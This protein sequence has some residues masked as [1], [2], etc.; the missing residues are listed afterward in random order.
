MLLL[1]LLPALAWGGMA[2]W[3]GAR[4]WAA[5]DLATLSRLGTAQTTLAYV[6]D[7]E[8]WT[9]F[10]L[11]GLQ[12]SVRLV[13]HADVSS[14]W[15]GDS[16][17]EFRYA[18]LVQIT[19][20]LGSVL[21][22][23]VLHQRTGIAAV[24]DTASGE[25]FTSSAYAT[26][27]EVPTA[28]SAIVL[29]LEDLP[30]VAAALRVRLV[31]AAPEVSRVAIRVYQRT[32]LN[33]HRVSVQWDRL[34]AEQRTRLAEGNVYPA[35]LLTETERT[36]LLRRQWKPIGP[37]GVAGRDYRSRSLFLLQ[38]LAG[39]PVDPPALPPGLFLDWRHNGTLQL[40]EAGAKLTLRLE[41]VA[42]LGAAPT[43]TLRFSWYGTSLAQRETREL[44]WSGGRSEMQ[45][46]FGGGLLDLASD[47]P[48]A[49]RAFLP[50][51]T[52]LTAE[53][54]QIRAFVAGP[55]AP[56]TFPILQLDTRATTP[57]RVD[58]RCLCFD[59]LPARGSQAGTPGALPAAA[60][61][62]GA[63][64]TPSLF[65]EMLSADDRV[66]RRGEITVPVEPSPYDRLLGQDSLA[67]SEPAK[68]H[69]DLPSEV[70]ALRFLSSVPV[71]LNGYNRPPD[72]PWRIMTPEDRYAPAEALGTRPAWFGMR[73]ADWNTLLAA[74]RSVL[75]ATH[76][77]PPEDDPELLAGHYDW[78]QFLPDGDWLARD[79]LAPREATPLRR[80][81][82]G[83]V[84][85]PLHTSAEVEL[86]LVPS[87]P[88][89]PVTPT[90]LFLR[91]AP[92][93][94]LLR[95]EVDGRTHFS[96]QVAAVRGTLPMPPLRA[97][98][99]RIRA[100]APAGTALYLNQVTPLPNALISRRAL[101][102]VPGETTFDYEKRTSAD[103]ERPE[104]VVAHLYTQPAP[105]STAR[106]EL[107]ITIEG[108]PPRSLGPHADFTL[109]E[110]VYDIRRGP[111]PPDVR[112]LSAAG[113]LGPERA[114]FVPFGPDL[115]PGR[116]R[117]RVRLSDGPEAL[118]SLTRTTPGVAERRDI[119]REQIQEGR[120]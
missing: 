59:A 22:E 99:R 103:A 45:V 31:S 81:A 119:R 79:V 26:A 65:Y 80:L 18:Y 28:A 85:S 33:E 77:R 8:V 87:T 98:T 40:P 117:I 9:R 46:E 64:A 53:A 15:R 83:T 49:I 62:A 106:Q 13:S 50:D 102:L 36:N 114:L 109:R 4:G 58:L 86:E 30:R 19:D 17:A 116:Y 67:L 32:P 35:T 41:P 72:L 37:S 96:A 78:E 54:P 66:L 89:G 115:P 52:E 92:G 70:V 97:G 71:L 34:T 95:L 68:L 94:G 1:M 39:E 113:L 108:G 56:V 24:R 44:P 118:L 51:G 101:R 47:Q 42:H 90:L 112:V 3:T 100:F 75:L 60:L 57:V 110:R 107:A 2:L 93:P 55:E 74:N 105:G 5:N 43:G 11:A 73:P 16:E 76:P 82:L 10:P 48:V 23:T 111:E 61:L 25:I 88:G 63:G 27:D 29:A 21:R 91:D 84:F 12:T 69:F 7:R 38:D 14:E 104:L 20:V 6:L 120:R